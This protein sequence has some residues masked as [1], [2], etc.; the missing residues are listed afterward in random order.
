MTGKLKQVSEGMTRR[1]GAGRDRGRGG[2]GSWRGRG[3]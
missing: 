3:R 2:A 1:G